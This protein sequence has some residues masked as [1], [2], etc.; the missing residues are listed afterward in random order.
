VTLDAANPTDAAVRWINEVT[1]EAR[2]LVRERLI[3]Q[4]AGDGGELS[5]TEIGQEAA[6]AALG[7]LAW[8]VASSV[9]FDEDAADAADVLAT[10]NPDRAETLL[11]LRRKM[12]ASGKKADAIRA[13]TRRLLMRWN[14]S[15]KN[16]MES[17]K[18]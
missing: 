13:W 8:S 18:S 17:E 2:G 4:W 9:A 10:L 5:T 16:D 7:S 14:N 3:E 12:A 15:P 6:D 11:A 1:T